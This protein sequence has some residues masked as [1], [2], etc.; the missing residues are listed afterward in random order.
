MALSLEHPDWHDLLFSIIPEW[1]V[2]FMF[3]DNGYVNEAIKHL[4]CTQVDNGIQTGVKYFLCLYI[5]IGSTSKP[6][7]TD[8]FYDVLQRILPIWADN[9]S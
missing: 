2:M 8:L 6:P 1:A 3:K 7:H 9:L 4:N 5:A